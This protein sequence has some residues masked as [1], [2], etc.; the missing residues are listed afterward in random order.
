MPECYIKIS[1]PACDQHIELPEKLIGESVVCPSCSQPFIVPKPAQQPNIVPE[2]AQPP[3]RTQTGWITGVVIML[4]SIVLL[5]VSDFLAGLNIPYIAYSPQAA[6]LLFAYGVSYLILNLVTK[7]GAAIPV[8][9]SLFEVAGKKVRR[10]VRVGQFQSSLVVLMSAIC[11][12]LL[13]FLWNGGL[14]LLKPPRDNNF[15]LH[16]QPFTRTSKEGNGPIFETVEQAIREKLARPTSAKFDTAGWI[17]SDEKDADCVRVQLIV[18]SQDKNGAMTRSKWNVELRK[19]IRD[20][21][22]SW[23]AQNVVMVEKWEIKQTP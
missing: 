19:D 8:S 22:P 16:G 14:M 17:L 6:Q 10:R 4:V 18:E 9:I 3:K 1:C 5:F 7:G 12:P 13:F 21:G 20:K 2:P 15:A 11:A 23:S